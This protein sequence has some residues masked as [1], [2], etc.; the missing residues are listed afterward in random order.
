MKSRR[1]TIVVHIDGDTGSR[2]YH[3]PL[4]SFEA[5]KLGAVTVLLLVVLF[6]AFAEPL[7]HAA[8]RVPGLEHEVASLRQENGRVQQL[9]AALSRAEANYQGLRQLLGARAGAGPGPVPS[10]SP[11]TTPSSESEPAA[12]KPAPEVMR[13]VALQARAPA[14]SRYGRGPSEPVH[15]PL[16]VGGFVTRGDVPPGGDSTE[17]HPGIDIAVPLG[18]PVRAAGGGMVEKAGTDS[19]YGLFVLLQHPGRYESMYGHASRLL[20]REGDS[21]QA[22]QVI[23]LSGSSG[24]STAPHLHFEIRLDGKSLDPLTMVKREN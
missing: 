18:S 16:D 12:P 22:G 10:S 13:A 17:A 3:L 19:A 14:P 8:A 2:K 1:V 11:S 4:W 5:G 21:V 24:R 9:A 23:A 15:W 7:T 20:V 6:F